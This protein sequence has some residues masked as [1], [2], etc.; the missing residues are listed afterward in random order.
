MTIYAEAP[1]VRVFLD[2]SAVDTTPEE[3]LDKARGVIFGLAVGNIYG[4]PLEFWTHDQIVQ[5]YPAGL[6]GPDPAERHRVM[7]DD[8]AQAVDLGEALQAPDPLHEL[9]R[10]LIEW[11]QTNGRGIGNTTGEVI[12]AL[13]D[14]PNL[15]FNP[16]KDVYEK[17]DHIAPN[18]G[19]MRCAPVGVKYWNDTENM[20]RMSAR[21][22]ALT[23]YAPLCQWSCI[24][25]SAIIALEL[26]GHSMHIHRLMRHCVDDGATGLYTGDDRIPTEILGK[27][28]NSDRLPTRLNSLYGDQRLFGHTLIALQVGLWAAETELKFKEALEEVMLAGGDT[29]TNGAVAGAV[30]G[31]RYGYEQI[32]AEWLAC[33][34]QP[35]RL[36]RLAHDLLGI[37]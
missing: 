26:R 22:C 12:A 33:V 27:V 4:I 1:A 15:S 31:A 6:P 16:A 18:G 20:I 30:L 25:V 21:T 5:R 23:H 7:D 14:D 17:R 34:P 24:M 37:L 35:E 9:R 28:R 13:R 2:Y 3:R 29:D 10:R 8:L 32:P 36:E 11:K 19:V